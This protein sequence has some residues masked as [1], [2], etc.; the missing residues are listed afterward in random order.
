M[1]SSDAGSAVPEN[2]RKIPQTLE[3]NL[4]LKI[5]I[6]DSH[7]MLCKDVTHKCWNKHGGRNSEKLKIAFWV[8]DTFGDHLLLVIILS[9]I[10]DGIHHQKSQK[11]QL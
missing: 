9:A 8:E 2:K 1:Q 4:N 7:Q 11:W 3:L 5:L 10:L 6:D